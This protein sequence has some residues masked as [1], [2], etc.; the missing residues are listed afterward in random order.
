M[1]RIFDRNNDGYINKKEFKMMTTA[2]KFSMK[3]IET[4]FAVSLKVYHLFYEYEYH[5]PSY[6]MKMAME[7][8]T[9]KSSLRY[10]LDIETGIHK[11]SIQRKC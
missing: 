11:V 7:N 10:F 1:I 2:S 9:T 4:V 6:A 8:W 5:V 3:K